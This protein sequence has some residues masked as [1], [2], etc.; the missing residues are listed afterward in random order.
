MKYEPSLDGLR[1][2]AVATVIVS[3]FWPSAGIQGG[4]GVDVFF[5]LSGF[6]ITTILRAEIAERDTI[7]LFRFYARRALR[8][9]PALGLLLI[10]CLVLAIATRDWSAIADVGF[11]GL[12]VMNWARAFDLTYGGLLGHT[13]SLAIEEQ[14]YF[15]WPLAVLFLRGK[16]LLWFSVVALILVTCWKAYLISRGVIV[17]RFYCGFDTHSDTLLIGC[18]LALVWR[19]ASHFA[20]PVVAVASVLILTAC[21]AGFI[22]G[23]RFSYFLGTTIIGVSTVGIIIAAGRPGILN[24]VLSVKPLVFIGKIS[25]GLYL[26]HYPFLMFGQARELNTNLMFV[27]SIGATLLSYYLVE[28]PF[29]KLKAATGSP[30]ELCL[31]VRQRFKLKVLAA[32]P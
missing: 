21:M 19:R 22:A 3:H 25:Y 13:W 6:L 26:W 1:A 23:T 9:A 16:S 14:F 4:Y 10:I 17:Q 24:R 2:I 27:L 7:N 29:L 28:I 11:T 5:V 12:Y 20:I 8:L 18:I 32:E 15:L 30:G 31:A